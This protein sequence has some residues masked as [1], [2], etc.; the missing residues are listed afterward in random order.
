MNEGHIVEELYNEIRAAHQ[1]PVMH[2]SIEEAKTGLTESKIGGTPYMPHDMRW[3]LDSK[4]EPM[5]LLA[6]IN[7][8]DIKDMPD[9]PHEGLLQFFIGTATEYMG[10]PL[11]DLTSQGDFRVFYQEQIDSSVTEDEVEGK[12][13]DSNRDEDAVFTPIEG[14]RQFRMVFDKPAIQPVTIDDFMFDKLFS[15][16]WNELHPDDRIN[17]FRELYWRCLYEGG[18]ESEEAFLKEAITL[19]ECARNSQ[20]GGYPY[21]TQR[22]PRKECE[23][24]ADR[25]TVLFQLDSAEERKDGVFQ[26]YLILWGDAGIANFFIN[27][28]A[29]RNRDFSNVAYTWDCS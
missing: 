26:D 5:D 28:E 19:N 1:K 29:L 4:G 8:T 11:E 3:P 17:G 13:P 24:I 15:E 2:F 23:E 7:C 6:Q 9:F 21:F 18:F 20:V 12:R 10:A 14:N 16:K 22:D 25:D 27:G